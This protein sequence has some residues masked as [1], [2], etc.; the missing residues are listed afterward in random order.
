MKMFLKV[1]KI[2]IKVIFCGILCLFFFSSIFIDRMVIGA[3]EETLLLAIFSLAMI[4][5]T[6][7]IF[8]MKSK[9]YFK[10][11]YVLILFG[12]INLPFILPKSRLAWDKDQCYDDG[13]CKEGLKWAGAIITKDYCLKHKLTWDERNKSCD[14][15]AKTKQMEL[16]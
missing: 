15:F 1:L 16:K 4:P 12:Y 6:C 8:F 11:L 7:V 2:L 10:V 9:W 3:N 14:M 13:Y 5:L